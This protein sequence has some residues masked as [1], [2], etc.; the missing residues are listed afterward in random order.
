[1]LVAGPAVMDLV[2]GGDFSYDRLGLVLISLGMGLYLSAATLNQA[3]LA[4]GQAR[5]ACA[6]WLLAAAGFV[7]FLIV[8]GFDDRVLQV[9]VGYVAAA[10]VLCG[11]LYALYR[12]EGSDGTAPA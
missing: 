9:E 1:M 10:L 3:L 11:L 7:G 8:P 4:R 5:Q 12:R 2:F 6:V